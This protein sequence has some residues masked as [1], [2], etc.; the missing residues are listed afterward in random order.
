KAAV[1][2]AVAAAAS[3]AGAVGVDTHICG[4]PLTGP[5]PAPHGPGMVIDGSKTVQ[6][7]F[8]PA[9]R[10]G[11]TVLEALGGPDKIQKGCATVKIGG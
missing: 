1:L 4:K 2:G 3:A 8:L 9:C 6:I 11:D 10:E 5:V 7:N